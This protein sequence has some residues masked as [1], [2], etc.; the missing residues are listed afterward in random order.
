MNGMNQTRRGVHAGVTTCGCAIILAGLFTPWLSAGVGSQSPTYRGFD[1]I[2]IVLPVVIL[3]VSAI[4]LASAWWY[5]EAEK[6]ST[7]AGLVVGVMFGFAAVMLIIVEGTNALLPVSML[8]VTLRRS[9]SIVS[10][11]PGVWLA[12]IGSVTALAATTGAGV[13]RIDLGSWTTSRDRGKL[14]GTLLLL[15]LAVAFGWLRYQSWIESSALGYALDLHGQAAPWIG[16]ASLWALCLLA[17]AILLVALSYV[18]VAGL[19]AACAGWLISFLAA[20]VM[21]AAESLAQL[22]LGSLISAVGSAHDVTFHSGPAVWAAFL[23]GLLIAM[24]GGYLVT[25]S[26]QPGV[27]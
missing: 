3:S 15:A 19:L 13:Q 16:P 5:L 12:L 27:E 9:S 24:V 10:A 7:Y 11:G 25:W 21:I 17:A 1:L 14:A 23:T 2:E 4:G 6:F 8:P 20:L 22:R 26:P 18:Q